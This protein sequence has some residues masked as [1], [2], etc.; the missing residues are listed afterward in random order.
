MKD[1]TKLKTKSYFYCMFWH[2]YFQCRIQI[3]T[4]L[5]YHVKLK[6]KD[7]FCKQLFYNIYIFHQNRNFCF[8]LKYFPDDLLWPNLQNLNY[9][10]FPPF[11]EFD[12]FFFFYLFKLNFNFRMFHNKKANL[13]RTYSN[14]L[15]TW[16]IK[17]DPK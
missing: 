1:S 2:T 6:T 4:F 15:C 7:L 5:H 12:F 17:V 11:E 10:R 13:L 3:L 8:S 16:C 14:I 9:R